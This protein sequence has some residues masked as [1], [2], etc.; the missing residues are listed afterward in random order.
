MQ[1]EQQISTLYRLKHNGFS[2]QLIIDCGAAC[3]EWSQIAR[4]TF[5]QPTILAFDPLH[6]QFDDNSPEL[7]ESIP[8][9]Q[10][11]HVLLGAEQKKIKFK[12]CTDKPKL[13]S[14]YL[15]LTTAPSNVAEHEATINR[16]DDIIPTFPSPILMKLDTQGSELDILRGAENL[17]T[18]TEVIICE[19]STITGNKDGPEF[20]EIAQFLYDRNLV[21][22]DMIPSGERGE[23]IAQH[24]AVFVKKDSNLRK[25]FDRFKW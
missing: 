8:N 20:F 24:D 7:W 23:K 17:L 19:V 22:Y 16:L 9:H 21:L 4:A 14:Y 10:L 12:V 5:P 15:D 2:P 3:G 13:S 11:F 6:Y 18:A 25:V 1:Y